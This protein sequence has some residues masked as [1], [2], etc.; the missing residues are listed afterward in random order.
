M[1]IKY[2]KKNLSREKKLKNTLS[3]YNVM[4]FSERFPSNIG[5]EIMNVKAS[6]VV[7]SNLL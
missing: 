1:C 3:I 4:G 5:K 2:L 7:E 6:S